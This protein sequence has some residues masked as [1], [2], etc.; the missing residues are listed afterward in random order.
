MKD[1]EN[2][3]L[4]KEVLIYDTATL[5]AHYVLIQTAVQGYHMAEKN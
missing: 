2:K 5:Y 1:V 3:Y 4:Y